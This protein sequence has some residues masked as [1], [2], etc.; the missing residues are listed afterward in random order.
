MKT[1]K[2]Q[3]VEIRK[4]IWNDL[5]DLTPRDVGDYTVKLSILLA[6]IGDD[7]AKAEQQ[8]RIIQA[9]YLATSEMK[10]NQA[11]LKLKTT[12]E[13]RIYQ[14]QKFFYKSCEELIRALKKRQQLLESESQNRY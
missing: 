3:I 13:Y 10:T 7:L 1:A 5:S 6:N 9:G 12:D 8:C 4:I 2:E 11:E 14:E